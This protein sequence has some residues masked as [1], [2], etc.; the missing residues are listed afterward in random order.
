MSQKYQIALSYIRSL[1]PVMAKR[2]VAYT[3]TLEAVFEE[4]MGVL[5]KIPGIGQIVAKEIINSKDEAIASAEKELEFVAKN[6]LKTLFY[7]DRNYPS[8][9]QHIPDAPLVLYYKGLPQSNDSKILSVVGTRNASSNGLD[10]CERIISDL[11]S[12]HPDL[13]IISG[14]AY[15]VDICAHKAALQNKLRTYAVLAHKLN[16]IYPNIHEQTAEKIILEGAVISECNSRSLFDKYGFVKR[17]RIVA[18]MADATLVIESGEKGGSLI[19]AE[20]ALSYNRDVLAVPGRPSDASSKGCNRLIKTNRAAMVETAEDIE[21]I[22]GWTIN[23]R[24]TALQKALFIELNEEEE[25]VLDIV[26]KQG[27]ISID[28]ISLQTNLPVSKVS[29]V[30]LS[31]EFKNLIRTRPGNC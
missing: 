28:F 21:Y 1:G 27:P 4:K 31:L 19:T 8:R 11:A 2:L 15:G 3:G 9:L 13:V 25:I 20:L 18:G 12:H 26:K 29:P 5:Q 17:N 6:K 16:M 14:L 30:L 22:M 7:L 23:K 24:N 10:V